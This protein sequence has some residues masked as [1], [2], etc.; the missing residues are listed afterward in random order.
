[1]SWAIEGRKEKGITHVLMELLA[2]WEGVMVL[3]IICPLLNNYIAKELIL[4]CAYWA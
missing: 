4:H 3:T 2:K 1:M